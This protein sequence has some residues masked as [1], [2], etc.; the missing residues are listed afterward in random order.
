MTYMSILQ[1]YSKR[2]FTIPAMGSLRKNVEVNTGEI[3]V[4]LVGRK[5]ST[6]PFHYSKK[7][8]FEVKGLET[9]SSSASQPSE[10][11]TIVT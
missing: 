7:I 1:N 9:A 3:H 10:V 11:C 6:N 5:N 2:K 8:E 4:G